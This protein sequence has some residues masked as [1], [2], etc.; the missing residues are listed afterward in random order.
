M[1]KIM[2]N[3]MKKKREAD[4]AKREKEKSLAPKPTLEKRN[5]FMSMFGFFGGAKPTPKEDEKEKEKERAKATK[6]PKET[7]R[8]EEEDDT[9]GADY[10]SEGKPMGNGY[11]HGTETSDQNGRGRARSSS[12]SSKKRKRSRSRKRPTAN[13]ADDTDGS[14]TSRSTTA[15][16]R[17]G[18]KSKNENTNRDIYLPFHW[19]LNSLRANWKFERLYTERWD[20]EDA[21]P[22]LCCYEYGD[23][24]CTL[25]NISNVHCPFTMCRRLRGSYFHSV[26]FSAS[27][28]SV[29]VLLLLLPLSI[30]INDVD[31]NQCIIIIHDRWLF[32]I[33]NLQNLT[34][35]CWE[36]VCW[37]IVSHWEAARSLSAGCDVTVFVSPI[38]TIYLREVHWFVSSVIEFHFIAIVHRTATLYTWSASESWIVAANQG[39]ERGRSGES[40]GST[41]SQEDW[42][43]WFL[44]Y[45]V[46]RWDH[47]LV[48]WVFIY[49]YVSFGDSFCLT[50]YIVATFL[51]FVSFLW[52]RFWCAYLR[53]SLVA[54]SIS[55]HLCVRS[56]YSIISSL[57]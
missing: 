18:A 42:M 33:W 44:N 13:G 55:C 27:L 34:I 39:K 3:E 10:M 57:I 50:V 23:A 17:G 51:N 46:C 40:R 47:S 6:T 29:A 32:E 36:I 15:G 35:F 4:R 53:P 19:Y 11:G 20:W 45:F 21:L 49:L 52:R 14:E 9:D 37:E 56:I 25:H 1:V 30:A 5:S 43:V 31:T 2:E 54:F 8:K 28:L 41:G 7:A 26:H 48:C 22:F 24:L 38:P 16:A 12:R